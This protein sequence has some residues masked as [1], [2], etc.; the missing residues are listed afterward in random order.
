MAAPVLGRNMDMKSSIARACHPVWPFIL[1][2]CLGFACHESTHTFS[3]SYTTIDSEGGGNVTINGVAW[4]FDG[5]VHYVY[6]SESSS[7][8]GST[9]TMTV[10]G[11][12]FGLRG[13]TIYVGD[14]EYGSATSGA[15]IKVTSE[16]VT[17]DGEMRGPL[18]G[19]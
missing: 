19:R 7:T 17:V 10:D 3:H 2:A 15:E 16:G 13:D 18:P 12:D 6:K 8:G 9:R 4:E 11:H 1:A 14:R 5:T